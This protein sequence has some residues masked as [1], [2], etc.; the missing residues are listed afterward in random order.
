MPKA[1]IGDAEIYYEES[2]QGEPLLLVPGLSGQGAFWSPQVADLSRDFRVVIHD[3]R[4]AGQST[5]SRITYSV[6]QMADDVLKLMDALRIETAHFVGHSTGGAIGQVIALDHPRRL[7]SL[8][9]SATWAGPDPYFRRV[10]ESR[11]EVLQT[12]GLEAY[13]RASALFL[14]PP[15]WVSAN[16]RVLTEQHRAALAG[17][18]PIEVMTSRIDAIVRHDRRARLGEIRVPT[19]VIVAQDDMITP[20]FYSDELASRVPGA[21]LVVLDGGGH[22]APVAAADSYNRAVGG[23]LRGLIGR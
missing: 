4:G 7:R 1:S 20:R 5:H 9:L 22:F 14:M 3:H 8:V 16:D 21:K 18:A 23:F 10:F 11:K 2:G 6:E 17:A 19:L 13:L 12:L 15:A